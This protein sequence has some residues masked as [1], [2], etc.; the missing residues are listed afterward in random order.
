[1]DL[2]PLNDIDDFIPIP[3]LFH[4]VQSGR[5]FSSCLACDRPLLADG[6]PY[7]IEKAVRRGETTFEY[8]MCF[9]C[10]ESLSDELSVRSKRRIDA[11][12]SER[13]DLADRR[14]SLLPHDDVEAWV[15][16]CILTKKGRGDCDEYQ[17]FAQCDG[18]DLLFAYAPFMISGEGVEDLVR[19]FSKKTR[20]TL[21]DFT[22]RYLGM[23]PE[24]CSSPRVP[25]F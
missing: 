2:P 12:V 11:Q 18:G 19:L 9:R 13:V 25:L 24:F 7:L 15:D 6:V 3:P 21:D 20:E 23:P 16:T 1:M 4:S 17:L 8:A 22:G 14:K 10:H 5:P